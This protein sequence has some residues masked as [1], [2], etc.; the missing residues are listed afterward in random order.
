MI[1]TNNSP[2]I[3]LNK[4]ESKMFTHDGK[5]YASKTACAKELVEGGMSVK[6][7]A[8]TVGI[9]YQTVYVNVPKQFG[10]GKENRVR[11]LSKRRAKKLANSPRKYSQKEIAKRTGLG[12]DTVRKIFKSV[13]GN[14]EKPTNNVENLPASKTN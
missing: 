1:E 5:E 10:G 6:V 11:Q 3:N 13:V 7:A 9:A 12:K 2:N 4:G 14:I 8:A